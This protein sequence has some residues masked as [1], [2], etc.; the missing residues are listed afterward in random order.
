MKWLSAKYAYP[1]VVIAIAMSIV[2]QIVWLSQ[3]FVE[4]RVQVRELLEQAVNNAAK[5][6]AYTS[7]IPA[8]QRGE[9]AR[10]FFLSSD[11]HKLKMAY[12]NMQT[13]YIRSQFHNDIVADST[14]IM[15]RLAFK[16]FDVPISQ[17]RRHIIRIFADKGRAMHYEQVDIKKMDSTVRAEM[18]KAGII[19]GYYYLLYNYEDSDPSNPGHAHPLKK[20]DYYSQKYAFNLDFLHK[21]QLVVPH[22]DGIVLFRMR[23]YL[24]SSL[25]M[26]MLTGAVFY[27]ILKLMRDQRLY[28]N[29]RIAFTSNMTHE[30]K[31]PVA[32][33]GVALESITKYHLQDNPEKMNQY[34]TVSRNE[35]KRLNVMIE[36]VL[37]LEQLDNGEEHLRNELFDVQQG[38]KQVV[39][40]MQ[41]QIDKSHARIILELSDDPCFLNGDPTH[42]INVFYNL[43]DNALKYSGETILLK[44]KCTCDKEHIQIRFEDNGPGIDRIYHNRIFERFFRVTDNNDV[45]NVNG[46]G[47]GLH[48]V[49]Q[50][51]ER[52]GGT[53]KVIS[54]L[55][56]G[57]KFIINLPVVK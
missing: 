11:F 33:V 35:L 37:N 55:G 42:L 45:H 57:S 46:S 43:I 17:K 50:I 47:L 38:L 28:A 5:S 51:I 7:F 52:H 1:L 30:L 19:S 41:L 15:I 23:Y 13:N 56:E 8:A 10:E 48:Y 27:F 3:L 54:E 36:K 49:K 21:Y 24:I 2:L 14:I 16:N 18:S 29:A 22:I 9:A 44:V 6:T 26:I 32:I 34:L 4:Q 40:S 53:I 31:T 20:A 39:D 25:V 12:D